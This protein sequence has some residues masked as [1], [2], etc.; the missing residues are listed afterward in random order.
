MKLENSVDILSSQPKPKDVALLP[1]F[2]AVRKIVR[3]ALVLANNNE[4]YSRRNN[5]RIRDLKL[6][7][8]AN[9]LESV[10]SWM[11]TALSLPEVTSADIAVDH[12]LRSRKTTTDSTG[13]K[14]ES[15]IVRF[16]NK[17][18][19]N[20]I[21]RNS[22]LLKNSQVSISDDLTTMNVALINRLKNDESISDAWSW[23]GKIFA[24]RTVDNKKV[25]ASR[26]FQST[27]E[28]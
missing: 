14:C 26:L 11:A 19:K 1:D 28:L 4:Q 27:S 5:V 12:P 8:D 10:A 22:K 9:M 7:S 24:L 17:D 2:E 21:M 13:S 6:P 18:V 23:Q 16:H 20:R 3:D 15:I 25:V